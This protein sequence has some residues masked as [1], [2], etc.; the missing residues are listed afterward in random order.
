MRTPPAA[1]RLR[2]ALAP[3]A[4][5]S[6][7]LL[8]AAIAHAAPPQADPLA[9]LGADSALI[10]EDLRYLSSDELQG[11]AVGSE[12]SRLA[13]ARL[14][15]RFAGAGLA[16][17]APG[18]EHPFRFTRRNETEERTGVNVLALRRG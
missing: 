3:S 10:L 2:H 17:L 18:G 9:A 8:G 12:G 13:R 11:R 15:E 6:T 5:L 16:P 4:L 7:A 14:A 1:R